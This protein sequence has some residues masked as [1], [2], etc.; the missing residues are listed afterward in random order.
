VTLLTDV[1]IEP[2]QLPG[3]LCVVSV[4]QVSP[5]EHH[6]HT[7]SA[8]HDDPNL[9]TNALVDEFCNVLVGI[10]LCG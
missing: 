1:V 9:R 4:Y 5:V 6:I 7:F 10:I 3:E 2:N 8:V